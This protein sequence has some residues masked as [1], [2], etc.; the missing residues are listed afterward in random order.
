[1][2]LLPSIT[3]N[4]DPILASGPGWSL[5]W[6]SVFWWSELALCYWVLSRQVARGGGDEE[7]A[8]DFAFY[9]WLGMVFGARLGHALFYDL[10]M[11]LARPSWIVD[12]A[13]SGG[14]SGH[15]GAL[16]VLIAARLFAKR[17]GMPTLEVTDRLSYSAAISAVV[18][19]LANLFNSELLGKETDGTWGMRF[20]RLD[21][22]EPPLRH[23]THFYEVGVGLAVLGV[24]ALC[25]RHWQREARPRGALTATLLVSYFPARF[26]IGFLK[27]PEGELLY[28][29]EVGQLLCLPFIVAGVWLL[30][31]SLKARAKAG[32]LVPTPQ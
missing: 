19:R 32:W 10:D 11:L 5:R 25:D 18:H 31:R 9:I 6:Y 21:T 14:A 30:W 22:F 20:P 8:S 28:G 26:L 24:L 29:L 2:S 3:W 4:V 13:R 12:F 23:P 7:E 17:R 1:V 27:E 15:G 16:G